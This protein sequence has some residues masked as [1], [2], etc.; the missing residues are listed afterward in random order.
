MEVG[1]AARGDTTAMP[2]TV[3]STLATHRTSTRSTRRR[4]LGRLAWLVS[5][6]FG[7]TAIGLLTLPPAVFGWDSG[8]FSPADEQQLFTLTNQ[9]RVA[10]GLRALKNDAELASLAR[11]RSKD[12]SDRDYFSH[13]IPPDGKMVF[14][15][16]QD[17]GYC[18]N[19]AGENLGWNT[20]PDD[21]AT[22]E[23]QTMF[24]NSKS[25]RDDILGAT[26]NVMGVGAFKGADGKKLWTV[27]FADKCGAAPTPTPTPTAKPT[28]KPTPKPTSAPTAIASHR[29]TPAPTARPTTKPTPAPTPTPEPTLAPT[30]EPTPTPEAPLEG[31]P[32]PDIAA[33]PTPQPSPTPTRTPKPTA[34]DDAPR[35]GHGNGQPGGSLRVVDGGAS[36]S[37]VDSIVGG[38]ASLFFGG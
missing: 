12:M 25:H 26:W 3:S 16:M 32:A 4:G 7:I 22:A 10:A 33:V 20:Y 18:F 21:Q 38:V 35:N 24:M 2:P 31:T 6:A 34:S 27:L 30:S 37:L 14:D 17:Q 13:N 36:Q 28:A 11:W 23:I 29:P 15:Y 5:I 8:S 9:A 1:L 19:L